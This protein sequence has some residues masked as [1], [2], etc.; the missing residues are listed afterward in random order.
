MEKI[1]KITEVLADD[2]IS[3]FTGK[4][5]RDRTPRPGAGNPPPTI[6]E[7]HARWDS[8][9]ENIEKLAATGITIKSVC[10]LIG[11]GYDQWARDFR[12]NHFDLHVKAYQLGLAKHEYILKEALLK[13]A[14]NGSDRASAFLL[15]AV[16]N[17][18]DRVGQDGGR[19][20]I[21]TGTE[22]S[23]IETTHPSGYTDDD[24]VVVTPQE[25]K[26][27]V[28][29]LIHQYQKAR[30]A[31]KLNTSVESEERA[32]KRAKSNEET[33]N[34]GVR[35]AYQTRKNDPGRGS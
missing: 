2:D 27:K 21:P 10:A 22:K 4:K 29:A 23:Y 19:N 17:I 25:Q 28:S 16:H 11:K 1:T 8:H 12:D 32:E 24:G 33:R 9:L 26:A 31:L 3:P 5:K 13:Q 6:Q 14:V 20:F 30:K 34:N 18:H 7:L 35:R 15:L